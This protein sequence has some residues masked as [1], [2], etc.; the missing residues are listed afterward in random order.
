VF[1]TAML[2]KHGRQQCLHSAKAA[3][4]FIHETFE[5]DGPDTMVCLGAGDCT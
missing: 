4:G 2:L 5:R 3:Q 1:S